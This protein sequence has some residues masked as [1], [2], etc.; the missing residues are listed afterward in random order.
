M[1]LEFVAS[2]YQVKSLGLTS[3]SMISAPF[4][5]A[6]NRSSCQARDRATPR[7]FR[8]GRFQ[9]S[10]PFRMVCSAFALEVIEEK[11]ASNCR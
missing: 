6:M 1:R 5:F 3:T 8:E 2:Q 9:D 11:A 4:H 7:A 10:A